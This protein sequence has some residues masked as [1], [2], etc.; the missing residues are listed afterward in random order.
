[1]KKKVLDKEMF[2]HSMNNR[3]FDNVRRYILETRTP[4]V[5]PKKNG[6]PPFA[7]YAIALHCGIISNTGM[8]VEEATFVSPENNHESRFF[9]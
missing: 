3:S 9:D 6:I 1:M 8:T 4:K 5:I 7:G 2:I